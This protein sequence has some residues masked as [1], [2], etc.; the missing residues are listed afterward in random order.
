L[1][2]PQTFSE[3]HFYTESIMMLQVIRVFPFLH[4]KA[5]LSPQVDDKNV[6]VCF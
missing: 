3:L 2:K 6:D 5:N 1:L 4:I